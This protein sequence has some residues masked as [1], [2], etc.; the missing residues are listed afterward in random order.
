MEHLR[1]FDEVLKYVNELSNT[2]DLPS[3]MVR[4][5]ALFNRFQRTV[6]AIDRKDHFPTPTL[7]QRKQIE[8]G[9]LDGGSQAVG[10]DGKAV[11]ASG[12]GVQQQQGT[13][14]QQQKE[15]IVSPE[16]RALL[17]REFS[18]VDKSQK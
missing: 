15:R 18:V 12:S 1:G 10:H 3:T 9:S 16:L 5:E 6:E 4:A 8:G 7:R 13:T 17:S 2:I 14:T 11:A